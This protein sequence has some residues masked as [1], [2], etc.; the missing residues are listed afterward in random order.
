MRPVIRRAVLALACAA[1]APSFAQKPGDGN[2]PVQRTPEGQPVA[3]LKSVEGNVLVSQETGLASADAKARLGE[4]SRVITTAN[5]KAV[6]AYDDGCEVKVD[7][8]Q[9]LEIDADKPCRERVVQADSILKEP[10][11]LALMGGTGAAGG[12]AAA[13]LAGSLGGAGLAAGVAG[14]TGLA[15]IASS[16]D[17]GNTSPN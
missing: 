12:A 1:L 11:G 17:S 7:P 5:A 15:A 3:T 6:V 10:A 9:R 13:A 14:V 4:G 8:N 2:G 16:R